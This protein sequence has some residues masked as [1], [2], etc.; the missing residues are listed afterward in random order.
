MSHAAPSRRKRLVMAGVLALLP[1]VVLEIGLRLAGI[2]GSV[3]YE[4][5]ASTGYRPAPH[6]RFSTMG[7]PVTIVEHGFRG[8][9]ATNNLLFVGDSVTYG[10][11]YLRDEETFPALLGGANG[12]VNGWGLR[13][14]ARFLERFDLSPYRA[15]VWVIPS[16]DVLRPYTTLRNG[17]ISTNRRM[18]LRTEYLLRFL[19]YGHLRPQNLPVEGRE[20]D[21]NWEAVRSTAERLRDGGPRLLLVFVPYREEA[22]GQAM[23]ETPYYRRMIADAQAAGIPHVVATPDADPSTLYRDSAHLSAAGS[24]WLAGVIAD[25]LSREGL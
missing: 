8:P 19:W 4:E 21:A 11:A 9:S 2:G 12:G 24:R 20:Y 3:I 1:F 5:D 7:H 18:W 22:M 6:Q 15:V 17:L 25:A 23:T 10:T 16:C 13:N 14:M